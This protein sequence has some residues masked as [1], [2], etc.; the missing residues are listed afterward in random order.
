MV[1][2]ACRPGLSGMAGITLR[3]CLDVITALSWPVDAIMTGP[4]DAI[5]LAVIKAGHL[6]AV[7]LVTAIAL[8]GGVDM[9]GRLAGRL[10]AIVAMRT[11]A[12]R[13]IR[14]IKPCQAPAIGGMTGIAG[15]AGLDMAGMFAGNAVAVVTAR[16][17]AVH[18]QVV[19]PRHPLPTECGMTEGTTITGT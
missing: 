17:A 10:G 16:T 11:G 2:A 8:L 5:G 12:R 15:R 18:R 14:M 6:P 1:E 9:Q 4:A 19:H 7:G 13:N 3:C